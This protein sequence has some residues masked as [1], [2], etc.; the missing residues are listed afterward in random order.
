MGSVDREIACSNEFTS[1][2]LFRPVPQIDRLRWWKSALLVLA[3]LKEY[4]IMGLMNIWEWMDSKQLFLYWKLKTF[5]SKKALWKSLSINSFW[6][7]RPLKTFQVISPQNI[8]PKTSSSR[9]S[10]HSPF[11]V[12]PRRGLLRHALPNEYYKSPRIFLN[13]GCFGW[14]FAKRTTWR[15]IGESS[16]ERKRVVMERRER[17]FFS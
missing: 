4:E 11:I 7:G 16:L 13:H 5:L 14:D 2:K 12:A 8:L 9:S 17:V 15:E 10:S 6:K 3:S 1:R